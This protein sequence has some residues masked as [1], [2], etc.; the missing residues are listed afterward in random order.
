MLD[1]DLGLSDFDFN[2]L[3]KLWAKFCSFLVHFDDD[4]FSHKCQNFGNWD[5]QKASIAIILVLTMMARWP[6]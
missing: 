4:S 1:F 5:L 3:T 6:C 2:S